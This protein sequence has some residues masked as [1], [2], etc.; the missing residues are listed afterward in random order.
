MTTRLA[1]RLVFGRGNPGSDTP[2]AL[3]RITPGRP[4]LAEPGSVGRFFRPQVPT[5]SLRA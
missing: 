2:D 3:R 4:G 5:R 1:D